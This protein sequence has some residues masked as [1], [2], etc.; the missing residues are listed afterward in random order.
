MLKAFVIISCFTLGL[1]ISHRMLWNISLMLKCISAGSLGVLYLNICFDI[2]S[3]LK[4]NILIYVLP[5]WR[6]PYG[7]WS[8]CCLDMQGQQQFVQINSLW[9]VPEADTKYSVFSLKIRCKLFIYIYKYIFLKK[10]SYT[11]CVFSKIAQV[12]GNGIKN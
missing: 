7:Y 3:I 10:L 4:L 8:V 1:F 12:V 9:S 11:L 2:W 5:L 6:A